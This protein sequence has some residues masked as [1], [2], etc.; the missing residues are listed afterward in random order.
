MGGPKALVQL[1]GRSFLD[2]GLALLAAGGCQPLLVVEGAHALRERVGP[3]PDVRW[4]H[5]PDWPRGPLSSLQAG[6]RA[7]L[8]QAAADGPGLD[9]LDGLL[10][11]HVERPRVRPQS[12]QK[13]LA[14]FAG[15]PQACWQP[16]CAG[17]S[18]HPLVLPRAAFTD[19]LALDPATASL[20]D[21]L[22]SSAW[23]PRR[24]KLALDDPGVLENLD[25]P[26]DLEGLA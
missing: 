21:L 26:E 9:G 5:N 14:A 19:L 4:V 7:A 3:R 15:E 24:R 17:R 8:E 25:R 12:V 11:H 6:L 13:L 20:R 2:H 10:V 22:R 23:A 18:G 1:A 16:S